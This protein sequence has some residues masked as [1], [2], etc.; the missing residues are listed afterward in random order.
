[1]DARRDFVNKLWNVGRFV[2][3]N[4]TAEQRRRAP[5]PAIAGADAPLAERWI[6]SRLA[7][8]TTECTRLLGDF[9]F[10]EAGRVVHD[11]IWDELADWY[12][13]AYKISAR[14]GRADGA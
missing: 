11:F 14:D 5:E 6:A 12:V 2:Q 1:L 7:Q 9:N 3:A 8:V 10:G 4:T 13:E